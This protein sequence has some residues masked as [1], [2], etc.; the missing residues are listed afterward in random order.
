MKVYFHHTK[1]QEK[2]Y[3]T[4]MIKK[5]LVEKN[6]YV[7]NPSDCDVVFVS[8]CD[9]TELYIVEQAK[10]MGKPIVAGGFISYMDFLRFAVDYVCK[11]EVYNFIDRLS[12]LKRHD[13]IAALEMI[14]TKEKI[15]V[16]DEYIDYKRNPLVKVTNSAIYWYSG[17]GC[18]QKCKFCALSWSRKY[19]TASKEEYIRVLRAIPKK[20]KLFPMCSH[21]PYKDL[22]YQSRLG[23]SDIRVKDYLRNPD[24]YKNIKRIRVGVE[25]FTEELRKSFGK[26]LSSEEIKTFISLTKKYNQEVTLYFIIGFDNNFIEFCEK[27]IPVDYDLKPKI[28][29]AMTYLDPQPMT[30]IQDLDI[31][32]K[33]EVSYEKIRGHFLNSSRRFRVNIQK[34][35][36]HSTWRTVMQ[37][38]SNIDEYNFCW[39]LRNKKDNDELLS[40]VDKEM[41]ELLGKKDL[42][43]C[44]KKT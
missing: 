11:G 24:G 16:L 37:R 7:D 20:T 43:E 29:I 23:I 25:F 17:K 5:M 30:P 41:P 15:G 14:S 10:K 1:L 44:L 21:L 18:P 6:L 13:D 42:L 19:Q 35:I 32:E 38:A 9:V 12:E 27:S 39:S 22:P 36:A 4:V 31:R 8:L 34:Y 33:T 26:P 28:K 3:T 2:E 40:I